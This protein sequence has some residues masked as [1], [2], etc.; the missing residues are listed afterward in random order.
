MAV[1]GLKLYSEEKLEIDDLLIIR[2]RIG[3]VFTMNEKVRVVANAAANLYGVQFI[4]PKN[5]TITFFTELYGA[6]H[7]IRTGKH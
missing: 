7:H 4:S 2:G 3:S 5:E 6:V 1:G